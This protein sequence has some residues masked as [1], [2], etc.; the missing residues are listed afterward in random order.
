[1]EICFCKLF[2]VLYLLPQRW[3]LCPELVKWWLSTWS[4]R[5]Y[6]RLQ[7]LLHT[8]H[9][10]FSSPD[11]STKEDMKTETSETNKSSNIHQNMKSC[12]LLDLIFFSNYYWI[13]WWF[14]FVCIL[15]PALVLLTWGQYKHWNCNKLF[16]WDDSTWF[17]MD[18][19]H[20][21]VFAHLKHCQMVAPVSWQLVFV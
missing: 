5:I 10:H 13:N 4:L 16:K 19:F 17:L 1:M 2:L 3:Q 9:C 6:F 18:V 12:L 8:R 11:S 14:L 21:E 15:R 20:F 7:I